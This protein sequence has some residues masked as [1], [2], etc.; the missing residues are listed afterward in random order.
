MEQAPQ[1][2]IAEAI[3]TTSSSRPNTTSHNAPQRKARPIQ[4]DLRIELCGRNTDP[5]YLKCFHL[6]RSYRSRYHPLLRPYY[7]AVGGPTT[8]ADVDLNQ[9][10]DETKSVPQVLSY[11]EQEDFT[12]SS[13]FSSPTA[14][15]SV[16]GVPFL[17]RLHSTSSA[18]FAPLSTAS[19]SSSLTGENWLKDFL[20]YKLLSLKLRRTFEQHV[21]EQQ[22]Q[23][24]QLQD[25]QPLSS[26]IDDNSTQQSTRQ[27]VPPFQES[28]AWPL[29]I[30]HFVDE[31]S[32]TASFIIANLESGVTVVVDPPLDLSRVQA[33]LIRFQLTVHS[34]F[35]THLYMDVRTGH[36]ELQSLHPGAVVVWCGAVWPMTAAETSP[37]KGKA[38]DEQMIEHHHTNT[39]NNN[40]AVGNN[41]A[42][43]SV[44]AAPPPS[45][46]VYI[47]DVL[48]SLDLGELPSHWSLATTTTAAAAPSSSSR[49]RVQGVWTPAGTDD[50]MILE[51]YIGTV[52]V[53]LFSGMTFPLDGCVRHDLRK[54]VPSTNMTRTLGQED[55]FLWSRAPQCESGSNLALN[56]E[57]AQV[58]SSSGKGVRFSPV[59][60]SR[61]RAAKVHE[62]Q[63][64]VPAVADRSN[65][66][67]A[68]NQKLH[69]TLS[70]LIE[71]Y[72]GGSLATRR[73][74][75]GVVVFPSHGGYNHMTHQL[76]LH[77]AAH[78]ADLKRYSHVKRVY[79]LVM[80]AQPTQ[81]GGQNMGGASSAKPLL[82]QKKKG[83][84]A[85]QNA[86]N[87]AQQST[88]TSSS[89]SLPRPPTIKNFDGYIKALPLLP[90]CVAFKWN[91]IANLNNVVDVCCLTTE[92]ATA[93]GGSDVPALAELLCTTTTTTTHHSLPSCRHDI[94]GSEQPSASTPQLVVD[95]RPFSSY[96]ARH[97][98]GSV[99]IPMTY[100][101]F[102][103][104]A[105]KAELWLSC[106][107]GAAHFTTP[108]SSSCSVYVVC[109]LES[110]IAETRLRCLHVGVP[111]EALA[112]VSVEALG[113][114]TVW[115]TIA[116]ITPQHE[117][118]QR[119]AMRSSPALNI[120]SHC[121]TAVSQQSALKASWQRLN[122][123]ASLDAL[124][125][126]PTTLVVDVRTPYEYKNGS[127][128]SSVHYALADL[129]TTFASFSSLV[130]PSSNNNNTASS[131][132]LAFRL[133]TKLH[134]DAI[135]GGADV[136]PH[137]EEIRKIIVYCA[138]GY[139]SHIAVSI[140]KAALE[141]E[142][143]LRQQQT[144][145]QQEQ[146][147]TAATAAAAKTRSFLADLEVV[148]VA[149]GALHIMLHR[150]DVWLVKDRSIICIS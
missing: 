108:S 26:G 8:T 127:H 53:A 11:A 38:D 17:Q 22:Q 94:N 73:E 133:I 103:F 98:P 123:V 56:E 37:C 72:F 119:S 81:G 144:Q 91:R 96:V 31:G 79:E 9:H 70:W 65:I 6:L 82:D 95:V 50:A 147:S 84:G 1:P 49:L 113:A 89:S 128:R 143:L 99:N 142:H 88:T 41:G 33:D 106:A 146:Q 27:A 136:T 111:A 57:D 68:E 43:S 2:I 93:R 61:Q 90:K 66:V 40:N 77:W 18:S 51:L 54:V 14:A 29:F 141:A 64:S 105:K 130:P 69:A 71:E 135:V 5:L 104:G 13:H 117:E 114:D 110:E 137:L 3:T 47:G 39:L 24:Q 58:L 109:G 112:V 52:R 44:S 63:Q 100:P 101:G 74:L 46:A 20:D 42:S 134:D 120:S 131:P 121:A 60:M 34:I 21:E 129:C 23:Q 45:N 67:S 145:Q 36:K 62:Q 12:L 150:P 35:L 149:G 107:L 115:Q 122:T 132:S 116:T 16:E 83:G 97:I 76:D 86:K 139:R 148:D 87:G 7:T 125:I 80:P 59:F 75:D 19:P 4:R 126:V 118:L 10:D 124:S 78:I 140:I 138:A 85:N 32:R 25:P 30:R 55:S 48:W 15:V 28:V 92:G 102:T